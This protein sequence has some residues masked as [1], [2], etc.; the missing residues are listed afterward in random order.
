MVGMVMINAL[1]Y[2]KD[3]PMALTFSYYSQMYK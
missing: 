3:R 2:L 1:T